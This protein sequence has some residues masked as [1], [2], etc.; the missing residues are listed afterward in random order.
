[1]EET[2]EES[3]SGTNQYQSV[4]PEIEGERAPDPQQPRRSNRRVKISAAGAAMR[5]LKTHQQIR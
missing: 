3:E 2:G 1:M 4:E 5:G